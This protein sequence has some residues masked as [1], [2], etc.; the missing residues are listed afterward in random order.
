MFLILHMLPDIMILSNSL[1][2]IHHHSKLKFQLE[3]NMV[4]LL[5]CVARQQCFL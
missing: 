4:H 5:T 2:L 3:L 1:C